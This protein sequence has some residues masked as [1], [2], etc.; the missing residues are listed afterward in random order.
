MSLLDGNGIEV[1]QAEGAEQSTTALMTEKDH[2]EEIL[3][4]SRR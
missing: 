1:F 2:M 3:R 4:S